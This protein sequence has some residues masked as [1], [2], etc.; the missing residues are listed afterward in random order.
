[1]RRISLAL[2][3]VGAMAATGCGKTS[4]SNTGGNRGVSDGT[5]H[6]TIQNGQNQKPV[7][8]VTPLAITGGYV[9]SDVGNIDCGEGRTGLCEADVSIATGVTL[10]THGNNG[11][12]VTGWA[13]DCLPVAQADGT[14][15]TT[16]KLTGASDKYVVVAFGTQILAHA[17]LSDPLA[18]EPM[19]AAFTRAQGSYSL[20]CT[21][22]HGATL[23]GAGLAVACASCHTQEQ[24]DG[25][26][27][28][29]A[30]PLPAGAENCATCHPGAGAQHQALYNSFADGINPA[31][32]K[33]AASIVSV[34][35]SAN[36]L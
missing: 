16:C 18:H 35:T 30:T 1:M 17:N 28:M 2:A 11:N 24:V 25:M 21:S 23:A 31:T 4:T 12:I 19:F 9:T 3:L 20:K 29:L 26:L 33:F 5:F 34:V 7:N 36:E 6:V 32:T 27:A 15:N 14:L 13:G 8:G 22:C 10:T